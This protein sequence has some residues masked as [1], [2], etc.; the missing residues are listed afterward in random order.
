[1]LES[2]SVRKSR[3]TNTVSIGSPILVPEPDNQDLKL[4]LK[5]SE[6]A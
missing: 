6:K 1:M 3:I 2:R 4:K 5:M